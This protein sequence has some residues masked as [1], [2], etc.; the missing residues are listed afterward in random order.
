MV[1]SLLCV[2]I[3]LDWNVYSS[4]AA[5]WD[6]NASLDEKV[7]LYWK[8]SPDDVILRLEVKAQS[9]IG[10]GWNPGPGEG[11]MTNAD[12]V[13]LSKI[14][15]GLKLADYWSEGYETPILDTKDHVVDGSFGIKD[16][17]I[18]MEFTRAWDTL[19]NMDNPLN[20]YGENLIIWAY[21]DEAQYTLSYHHHNRGHVDILLEKDG[22]QEIQKG[23]HHHHHHHDEHD[24]DEH[25]NDHHHYDDT[26]Y[27]H[28]PHD[29]EDD[30]DNHHHDAKDYHYYDEDDDQNYY[31]DDDD[32]Q[33][34]H[35]DDDD[36]HYHDHD[37]DDQ[38]YYHDH[39]DDDQNYYHDDDDD[40]DDDDHHHHHH[41][42]DDDDYHGGSYYQSKYLHRY[43]TKNQ[44]HH[45]S[46][47]SKYR[48]RHDIHN[49]K[50]K[51]S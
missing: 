24:D 11:P 10:I 47:D 13:I 40:D 36:H 30:D 37:D 4:R 34:Y 8:R 39:D 25:D 21:G 48:K 2:L 27:H 26:K 3:L 38:N 7:K 17:I 23:H 20:R 29:D 22:T 35:D 49:P 45:N 43:S 33:N 1:L 50:L 16:D 28:Y 19:D 12:M 41:D 42:D 31:H 51:Q 14:G 46:Q 6:G 5:D 32:D 18:W 44:N 15:A 9:W